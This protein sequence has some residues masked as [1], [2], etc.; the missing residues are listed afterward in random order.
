MEAWTMA[1]ETEKVSFGGRIKDKLV[2]KK[3][4]DA[5]EQRHITGEHADPE[6][7]RLPPGQ[8]LVEKWPVLDLGITPTVPKDAFRLDVAGEIENPVSW[9]WAELMAQPHVRMTSDIHCVTS[10]SRYDNHWEGISARHLLSIV[11]PKTTAKHVLFV[12][13]DN[14][15]TNVPFERFDDDDV[16]LAHSWEG[17]PLDREHGGP[18]RIILPKLYLWKSAKWIKRIVIMA[19][20]MPGYWEVR[21]YHNVGDPWEEERYSER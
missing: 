12:S 9:S 17:K 21:G 14:Y 15:T 10:W 4:R 16:L 1:D 3:E 7:R 19:R 2:A 5:A 13:H 8:R 18:L 6:R 20:D 11:R